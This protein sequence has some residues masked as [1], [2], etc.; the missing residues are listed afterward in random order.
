MR[1]TLAQL[2]LGA[3]SAGVLSMQRVDGGL[4]PGKLYRFFDLVEVLTMHDLMIKQ[5]GV[6]F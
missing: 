5:F 6:L 2:Y 4:I 1:I 3:D